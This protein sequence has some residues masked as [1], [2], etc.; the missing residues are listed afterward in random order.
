M[1]YEEMDARLRELKSSRVPRASLARID[2][3]AS[4]SPDPRPWAEALPEQLHGIL[5]HYLHL[6]AWLTADGDPTYRD[7]TMLCPGCTT[8]GFFS[9]GLVHGSGNCECGWPGTLYHL[10][11]DP[12]DEAECE[13]CGE[14]RPEHVPQTSE[15]VAFGAESIPIIRHDLR[16]PKGERLGDVFS[17][18]VVVKFDLLLWAHPYEVHLP[19]GTE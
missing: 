4:R 8:L 2:T 1:N 11:R 18:P 10:V 19:K 16:C 14:A 7:G 5:D 13:R 17:A 6:F 9:F 12:S 3:I 15:I